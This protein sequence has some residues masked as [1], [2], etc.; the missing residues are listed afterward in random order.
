MHVFWTFNLNQI[1]GNLYL[2]RK[3][4]RLCYMGCS[5]KVF[6]GLEYETKLNFIAFTV[7]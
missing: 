5:G 6:T 1:E 7:L 3:T 2:L 4:G